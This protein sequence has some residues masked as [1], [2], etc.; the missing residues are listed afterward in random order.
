MSKSHPQQWAV[1]TATARPDK[2]LVDAFAS[3]PTTQIADSGGPVGVVGPGINRVAGERELCGT[4]LTLWTKPGDILFVIKSPD[5]VEAGDVLVIDG[6]GRL[7]AAVIGDILGDAI[8]RNGAV[9]LVVDGVVRDTDGLDRLGLPTFARGTY[10]TTGSKE[11]PG[12]LNVRI[13]CGGVQVAPGDIVRGDASG[14]VII[15]RE[16]AQTVFDLTKAVEERERAWADGIAN[17]TPLSATLG[18]DA[19]IAARHD[20]Q[21]PAP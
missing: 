13:Q 11:G 10:P 7:D 20:D 16:H 19:K 21:E 17:G 14:L 15:P 18:L 9:G 5:L 3:Y 4:A 2:E 1:N 8:Q 12:A 6:A